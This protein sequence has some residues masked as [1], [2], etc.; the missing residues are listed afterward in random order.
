[1]DLFVI[2]ECSRQTPVTP[3]KCGNQVT[4]ICGNILVVPPLSALKEQCQDYYKQSNTPIP[5]TQPIEIKDPRPLRPIPMF[6]AGLLFLY[7]M[8]QLLRLPIAFAM[9]IPLFG[10]AVG[11]I[12]IALYGSILLFRISTKRD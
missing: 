8:W 7:A 6:F 4:C 5:E 2:C 3:A 1:M 12:A 10:M 9:G 11:I